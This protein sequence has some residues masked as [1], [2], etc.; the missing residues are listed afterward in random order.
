MEVNEAVAKL[1][2][3]RETMEIQRDKQAVEWLNESIRIMEEQAERIAIMAEGTPDGCPV[4]AVEKGHMRTGY[5]V[6]NDGIL[7][8]IMVSEE[9]GEPGKPHDDKTIPVPVMGVKLWGSEHA[10]LLAKCLVE[11]A[12]G[13]DNITKKTE[14][15]PGLTFEQ[16]KAKPKV[17]WD[18]YHAG[19]LD[20]PYLEHMPDEWKQGYKQ[21]ACYPLAGA[22]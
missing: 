19:A 8:F 1:E 17:W 11:C 22:Q 4:V 13:A 9:Y 6:V 7:F 18:G 21:A 10:R 5:N 2:V 20:E 14:P 12:D 16:A 3:I 15:E